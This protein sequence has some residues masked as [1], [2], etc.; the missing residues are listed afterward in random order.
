MKWKEG[1]G[2]FIFVLSIKGRI[3]GNIILSFDVD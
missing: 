2:W 1:V 3:E